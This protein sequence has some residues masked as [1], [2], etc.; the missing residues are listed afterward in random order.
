MGWLF[1]IEVRDPD[2]PE[3]MD[4]EQGAVSDKIRSLHFCL[5]VLIAPNAAKQQFL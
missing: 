2:C 3:W 5:S 1:V 4:L